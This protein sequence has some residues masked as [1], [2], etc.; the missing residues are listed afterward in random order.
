MPINWLSY[1]SLVANEEGKKTW[2]F[3]S[4]AVGRKVGLPQAQINFYATGAVVNRKL[5]DILAVNTAARLRALGCW[6]YQGAQDGP[7]SEYVD[8]FGDCNLNI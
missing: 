4:Q 1:T 5:F 2:R 7:G 8:I 6:S 3:C